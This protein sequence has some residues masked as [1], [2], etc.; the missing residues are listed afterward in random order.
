MQEREGNTRTQDQVSHGRFS[1]TGRPDEW[2]PVECMRMPEGAEASTRARSEAW[3]NVRKMIGVEVS[4]DV[5]MH[6]RALTS[7]L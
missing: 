5:R 1:G 2:S 4:T 3:R 6:K 7:Q